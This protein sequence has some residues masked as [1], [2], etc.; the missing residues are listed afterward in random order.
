[1]ISKTLLIT[2]GEELDQASNLNVS[3][4]NEEKEFFTFWFDVDDIQR[5]YKNYAGNIN[6]EFK[7][8]DY[9]TVP[10]SPEIV[11]MLN[12]KFS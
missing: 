2:N 1:M 11:T 3:L 7:D 12:E 6:L 10:C 8:G 9:H 4:P 5:A